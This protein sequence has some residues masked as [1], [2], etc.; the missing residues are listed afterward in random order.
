MNKDI[1]IE[2]EA[3]LSFLEQELGFSDVYVKCNVTDVTDV[4]GSYSYDA[5][6][7]LDYY[8]YREI[9]YTVEDVHVINED[10][11]KLSVDE[12]E[13]FVDKYEDKI[14]ELLWDELEDSDDD[15]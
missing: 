5:A 15:Y 3:D 6:S 8:G 7:D 2:L 9:E 14:E 11:Y 12:I 1:T 13:A 10:D 4:K